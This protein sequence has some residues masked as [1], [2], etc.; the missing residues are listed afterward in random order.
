M[1]IESMT[2]PTS[3]GTFST[4]APGELKHALVANVDL[5]IVR[6][7]DE[8]NVSVLYG[9]CQH[10]GALMA[11][12]FVRGNDIICGVHDWDYQFKSGVSSYDP[13]EKLFRFDSVIDNDRIVVD[14]AQIKAWEKDNPQ[15]YQRDDYLGLYA[16]NRTPSL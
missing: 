16:M 14:E 9:R 12:G 6:W 7:P 10:R 5:V 8:D 4:L 2:Q 1:S 11:D 15:P 3:I 13:S